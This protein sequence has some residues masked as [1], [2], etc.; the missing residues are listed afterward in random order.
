M[1]ADTWRLVGT[2]ASGGERLGCERWCLGSRAAVPETKA[3]D[4]PG[5]CRREEGNRRGKVAEFAGAR[6]KEATITAAWGA[7]VQQWGWWCGDGRRDTLPLFSFLLFIASLW[8]R[9]KDGHSSD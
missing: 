3:G 8:F 2:T 6:G 4:A 9:K 5:G 1:T 7:T